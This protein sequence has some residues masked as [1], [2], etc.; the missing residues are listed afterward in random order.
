MPSGAVED[1]ISALRAQL[2]KPYVYGTCGPN[3][4]DCSGLVYYCLRQVGVNIGRLSSAGYSMYEAWERIDGIGNLQR[5]DLMF[6]YNDAHTAISHVAVYLG[7]NQ[8]IHASSTAGSVV[9]SNLGSWYYSHFGWGRRV[10]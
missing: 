5:G 7:N 2:G 10:F 3:T 4:F 1:F 9:I 6:F 8:L